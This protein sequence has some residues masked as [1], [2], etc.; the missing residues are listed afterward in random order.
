MR[1]IIDNRGGI[2]TIIQSLNKDENFNIQIDVETLDIGDI[3]TKMVN[4][5]KLL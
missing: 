3:I 2:N 4:P 5:R 1:I